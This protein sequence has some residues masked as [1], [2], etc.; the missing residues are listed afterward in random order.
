MFAFLIIDDMKGVKNL[1][2]PV[3]FPLFLNVIFVL[4][5][6]TTSVRCQDWKH[7]LLLPQRVWQ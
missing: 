1:E 3:G 4:L 2:N 6:R 5:S 7:M